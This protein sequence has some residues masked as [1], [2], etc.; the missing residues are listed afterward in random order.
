MGRL[1]EDEFDDLVN[2]LQADVDAKDKQ[3]FSEHALKLGTNPYHK[4]IPES[5]SVT[6]KWR[7][8]CGDE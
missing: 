1:T 3:D 8:P 6:G 2:K 5:Y 4:G 7:G